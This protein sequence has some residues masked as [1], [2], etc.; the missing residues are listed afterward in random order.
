LD[1]R[2]AHQRGEDGRGG[3]GG[4]LE[5]RRKLATDLPL[6]TPREPITSHIRKTPPPEN[7]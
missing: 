7:C 5:T 1:S 3:E 4:G 2:L 6:S